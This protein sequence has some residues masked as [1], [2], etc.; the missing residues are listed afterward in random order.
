MIERTDVC[1]CVRVNVPRIATCAVP[2]NFIMCRTAAGREIETDRQTQKDRNGGML[3]I[4][5]D[6]QRHRLREKETKHRLRRKQTDTDNQTQKD[7]DR[8]RGTHIMNDKRRDRH[9]DS[10]SQRQRVLRERQ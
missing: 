1:V 4:K 5:S 10:G 2:H 3:R 6:R 9:K 8:N 7:R